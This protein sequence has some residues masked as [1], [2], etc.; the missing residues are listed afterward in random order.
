MWVLLASIV[1]KMIGNWLYLFVI[2]LFTCYLFSIWCNFDLL[3]CFWC[4]AFDNGWVL[5]MLTLD[6]VEL[7]QLLI[8]RTKANPWAQGLVLEL[9]IT[10]TCI[11]FWASVITLFILEILHH[12]GWNNITYL[13]LFYSAIMISHH[14]F[15]VFWEFLNFNSR[16]RCSVWLHLIFDVVVVFSSNVV[17]KTSRELN[18]FSLSI[19]DVTLDY[20]FFCSGLVWWW[21]S[22]LLFNNLSLKS[23]DWNCSIDV[24]V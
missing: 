5:S 21:K 18:W 9:I 22:W 23:V 20:C 14:N 2:F 1:C 15:T 12:L 13:K 7:D 4:I 6:W 19:S 3:C 11:F 24:I 8:F 17:S 16:W 10:H